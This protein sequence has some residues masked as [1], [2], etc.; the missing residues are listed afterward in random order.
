MLARLL[1]QL[2]QQRCHS[3]RRL[4]PP[5]GGRPLNCS[6]RLLSPGVP[7]AGPSSL[8]SGQRAW[9]AHPAFRAQPPISQHLEGARG[10]GPQPQAASHHPAGGWGGLDSLGQQTGR[11]AGPAL[12]VGGPCRVPEADTESLRWVTSLGCL[13]PLMGEGWAGLPRLKPRPPNPPQP[14][15]LCLQ[16]RGGAAVPEPRHHLHPGLRHHPA[17]HRHV[18]PQRQARTQDEAG[19]LC[20]EPPR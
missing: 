3:S 12:L 14:A 6:P 13:R 2:P 1:V 18:Q 15:V 20:Q 17:Q 9:R 16:P 4:K 10:C 19:G 8:R 5:G 7:R 11:R